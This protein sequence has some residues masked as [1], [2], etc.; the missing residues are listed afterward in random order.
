[1]LGPGWFA[2]VGSIHSDRKEDRHLKSDARS[3]LQADRSLTSFAHPKLIPQFSDSL[4]VLRVK[5]VRYP[6][7]RGEIQESSLSARIPGQQGVE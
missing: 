4:E 3:R 7:E 1:M 2:G 5:G 6:N